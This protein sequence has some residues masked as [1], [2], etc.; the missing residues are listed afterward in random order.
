MVRQ[1]NIDTMEETGML[2]PFVMS[3]ALTSLGASAVGA[4]GQNSSPTVWRWHVSQILAAQR[5]D[6]E[7]LAVNEARTFD[8]GYER[9]SAAGLREPPTRANAK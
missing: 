3:L 7:A 2:K 6:S 5:A 9:Y 4:D 8:Q 1:K